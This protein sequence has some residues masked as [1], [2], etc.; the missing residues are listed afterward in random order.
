[1]NFYEFFTEWKSEEIFESE[2]EAYI[3]AFMVEE[4]NKFQYKHC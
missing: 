3:N 1:M 2:D 4:W